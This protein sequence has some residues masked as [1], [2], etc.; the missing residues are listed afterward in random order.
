MTAVPESL[1]TPRL[2][3]RKP[4]GDDAPLLFA[5]YAQDS[6][7]TRYL[8]WRPHQ[9]LSESKAI[10]EHFLQKWS[11]GSEFCWFL[12]TRSENEL[13]GSIAARMQQHEI[14]LGYALARKYW[15]RGL[16]VEAIDTVTNW[17]FAQYSISRV[18]AV[19]DI[20]NHASARVLE[21]AGF[22]REAVLERWAVHPN[23]S[24][25]PRDCYLYVKTHKA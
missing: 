2:V 20:E 4:S 6:Q 7:V 25:L 17:A 5:S 1:P 24:E 15:R 10:I 18:R 19:C 3:L 12:F 8:M 13:I 21:K 14:D 11:E 23:I 9:T 16:M 22:S